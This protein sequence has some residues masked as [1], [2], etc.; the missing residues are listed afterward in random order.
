M[1]ACNLHIVSWPAILRVPESL[2]DHL[3]TMLW[4]FALIQDPLLPVQCQYLVCKYKPASQSRGHTLFKLLLT[5]L[6]KALWSLTFLVL[7]TGSSIMYYVFALF[8][9]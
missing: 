3:D 7:F 1:K 6:Q 8:F 9:L 2:P 4:P 5:F